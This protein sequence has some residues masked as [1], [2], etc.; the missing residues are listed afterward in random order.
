MPPGQFAEMMGYGLFYTFAAI[1]LVE[2]AAPAAAYSLGPGSF[3]CSEL[4]GIL[5]HFTPNPSGRRNKHCCG[6]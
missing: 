4:E 2:F 6:A 1:E 3:Q 5:A